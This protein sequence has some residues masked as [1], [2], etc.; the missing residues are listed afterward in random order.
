MRR[1]TPPGIRTLRALGILA[2]ALVLA[3]CGDSQEPV[4]ATRA[5]AVA[6]YVELDDDRFLADDFIDPLTKAREGDPSSPAGFLHGLRS[7][8]VVRDTSGK[9]VTR[10]IFQADATEADRARIADRS[11]ELGLGEP[12]WLSRTDSWPDCVGEPDC[13]LV[14]DSPSLP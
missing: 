8:D 13:D 14:G 5:D 4:S 6:A 11:L 9:F 2:V 3:A 7:M 10:L 1:Q 12:D